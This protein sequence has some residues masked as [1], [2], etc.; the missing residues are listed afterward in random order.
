[1]DEGGVT[2]S[3]Q[4]KHCTVRGDI[5]KCMITTCSQHESWIAIVRMEHIK[6]LETWLEWIAAHS[7]TETEIPDDH[8]P[9]INMPPNEGADAALRGQKITEYV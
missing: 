6:N 9:Y 8:H 3:D 2:M 1:M 7:V 4:C 5:D